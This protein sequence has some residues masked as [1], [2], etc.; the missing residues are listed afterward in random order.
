M[1]YSFNFG[2]DRVK[3]YVLDEIVKDKK[4]F[5]ILDVGCG[6]GAYGKLFAD[7]PNIHLHALDATD[8]RKEFEL[9]KYYESFTQA[10]MRDL[11]KLKSLGDFDL[12]IF[13]DVLEHVNVKDAQAVLATAETFADYILV[14][15]PYEYEQ[16]GENGNHYQD[17]LQPDLTPRIVNERYPKLKLIKKCYLNGMEIYGYYIMKGKE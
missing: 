15:V 16:V 9:D 4:D 6:A 12:V 10:D 11:D 17:H 5:K 3:Q 14:A 8:Y 13:G 2:K 1:P 7:C